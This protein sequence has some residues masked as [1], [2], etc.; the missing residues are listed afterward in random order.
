MRPSVALPAALG[1]RD[2]LLVL[3]RFCKGRVWDRDRSSLEK[4]A[5]DIIKGSY[6]LKSTADHGGLCNENLQTALLNQKLWSSSDEIAFHNNR[7]KPSV[8]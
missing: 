1:S 8:A 2:E 7:C 5:R 6:E 3:A 4:G